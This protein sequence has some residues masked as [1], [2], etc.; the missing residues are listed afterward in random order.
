MIRRSLQRGQL[1]GSPV[2]DPFASLKGK[3]RGKGSDLGDEIE[4]VTERR[5]WENKSVPFLSVSFVATRMEGDIYL[6]VLIELSQNRYHPVKG[7]AVKFR[8]AD[9]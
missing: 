5:A 4:K 8:V 7:E 1:A 6:N 9:A 2:L 3:L